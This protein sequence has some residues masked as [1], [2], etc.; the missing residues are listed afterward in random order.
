MALPV[1]RG[2]YRLPSTLSFTRLLLNESRVLNRSGRMRLSP[3][4]PAAS[5]ARAV[6][7]Y[8]SEQ[9]GT[10][11]KIE[12]TDFY[13]II[14][15]FRSKINCVLITVFF[16]QEFSVKKFSEGAK[17][18]FWRVSNLLS[19]SQ[20]ESLEG[21]VAKDMIGELEEKCNSLSTECKKALSV[22]PDQII[23]MMARDVSLFFD[24]DGRTF[25]CILM[26]FWYLTTAQVPDECVQVTFTNSTV[27]GGGEGKP[28]TKRLLSAFYEF[29]RE[30]TRGVP[31][32]WTITRIDYVHFFD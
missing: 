24:K 11:E 27:N 1:L 17:Q 30:F 9:G 8:S 3:S 16:D 13:N 6:R 21:L 29:Q 12:G 32:D 22:D 20:F 5:V 7:P 2:C 26:R 4:S 23:Y 18:A 10:K 28:E 25:V 31:P 19:Q 15:W 14:F